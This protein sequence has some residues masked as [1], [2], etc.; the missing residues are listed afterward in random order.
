MKFIIMLFF[1][2]FCVTGCIQTEIEKK[3]V[4][5]ETKIPPE[6]TVL[7]DCEF[8]RIYHQFPVDISEYV[9]E[10]TGKRIETQEEAVYM[11]ERI[12]ELCHKDGRFLDEVLINVAYSKEENVWLFE[13]SIDQRDTPIDEL[14]EYG[15]TYVAISGETGELLIAWVEEG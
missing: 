2:M 13:Y 14:I 12:L 7:D 10:F 1:T 9:V 4:A 15:S 5:E 8:L 11:G 3:I 6:Y